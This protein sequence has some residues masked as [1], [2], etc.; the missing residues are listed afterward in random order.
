MPRA[1]SA[2]PGGDLFSHAAAERQR[3]LAPL[4]DRMRPRALDEVAGQQ[5]LVGPGSPLRAYVERG[6][7][8]SML[9]WGPPGTGKTTL[10]RIV[11]RAAGARFVE[12][13]ATAA[14]LADLRSAVAAAKEFLG[15]SGS[16]T[17]LFVD[18]IHRWNRGQQD[19]LLPSVEDGT[20]SLIGAT[21]ENPSFAVNAALLSRARVF[22]LERL[23]DP[24]VRALLD[25]ALADDERGLGK[26][27][28]V[29]ADGVLDGI[30]RAAD[31]DAR[32][33]LSALEFAV[34]A[35]RPDE[36]GSI[37]LTAEAAAS[38]TRRSHLFYD[39]TGEEHYNIISALHKSIRGSDPQASLYW[40]GRMLRAGEDPRYVTRRLIRFA[41]EDVGLA[42]PQ[43]LAQAL[44][45]HQAVEAIGMPECS[46][47]VA[48]AVAYLARAPKSVAV[49]RAVGRVNADIDAQP[50]EPVPVHLR[51]AP[52]KLMKDLGYGKDYVYPP[53]ADGPVAQEYL[54]AGL[55]GRVYLDDDPAPRDRPSPPSSR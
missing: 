47:N 14:S 33:A 1:S 5:A 24:D 45:A 20:V 15:I 43:A 17:V 52:T 44:A 41:S 40:L 31:G 42:D 6:E 38:A 21:T 50:S 23:D 8:P 7:V 53:D 12:L 30:A 11:A 54:P 18:E 55:R 37:Q 35:C 4:A 39:K 26:E 16:R 36:S 46:V 29:P 49:Y 19:A 28:V 48:Q 34:R 27:R 10:A 22:V 25:R 51:N 3:A 2:Q 32:R 13:S 9:L